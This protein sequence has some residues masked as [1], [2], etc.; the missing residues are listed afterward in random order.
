MYSY[1]FDSNTRFLTVYGKNGGRIMDLPLGARVN[2]GGKNLYFE[3]PEVKTYDAAIEVIEKNPCE[4][5]EEMKLKI[6]FYDDCAVASFEALAKSDFALYELELFR[7][8]SLGIKMIDCLEWFSPQ[9]RNYDGINRAFNKRFS[10]CSLDGYFSP[11]PLNFTVGN[12]NGLVSFGLLDLPDS[13]EYRMTTRLG[14]IVEKPCGHI[15]KRAGEKYTSPRLILT[16]PSDEYEGISLFRKKLS[17]FGVIDENQAHV[18]YDWWRR[19]T[20]VTYGDEMMLIQHNWFNDDDLDSAAFN[21]KWLYDWLERAERRLGN[22]EFTV[23]VDAFWQYRSTPEAIPDESRFPN[24]RG[25]IDYCH[26]RGHKVLLWSTPYLCN[27]DLPFESLAEKYDMLAPDFF[28][29]EPTRVKKIDFTSDNAEAYLKELCKKFF[30]NGEGELDADGVKLDFLACQHNPEETSY[31]NVNN[32]IGIK[33]AYRFHKLYSEAARSVKPDVLINTSV[34]DPRFEGFASANRLHDIQKVYSER[35]IRARVSSLA[36]PNLLIDSDGA[37]MISDWVKETYIPAVVYSSPSVYYIDRFHNSVSWSDGEMN[38][39]GSLVALAAKKPDGV[40]VFISEGNW[41]LKSG[42]EVGAACF[43]SETVVVFSPDGYA[44]LF[45]WKTGE[46]SIPFFKR[47]A[48][49]LPD[50]FSLDADMLTA[51]VEAGKVY[52]IKLK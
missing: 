33:E 38:A 8:G 51:F 15:V 36:C 1:S 26:E 48:E 30:G 7:Q 35:E 9:P 16:F 50:G 31:K 25:F 6:E 45:S 22:T 14:V 29:E 52:K 49:S 46:L 24:F 19:P 12:R 47:N 2:F 13:F 17:D 34:C 43:D 28:S 20:A 23:I 37:I 4:A 39:L 11:A 27:I 18:S 44:Y 41:W 40:P 32:G 5:L 42:D 3:A 21:E 10:D